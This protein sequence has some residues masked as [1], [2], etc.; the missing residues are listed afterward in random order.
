MTNSLVGNYDPAS[1]KSDKNYGFFL[2]HVSILG[3]PG[4]PR[5]GATYKPRGQQ[6]GEGGYWNDYNCLQG[7][8]GVSRLCLRRQK[9]FQFH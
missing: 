3:G 8:E 1:N 4:H 9:P 6:R 5:L 2:G 7:G